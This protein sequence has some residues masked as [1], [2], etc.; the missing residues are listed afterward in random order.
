MSILEICLGGDLRSLS[1]L[2]RNLHQ[3]W[4]FVSLIFPGNL[5]E[6]AMDTVWFRS[7][8]AILKCETK[9]SLLSV[10]YCLPVKP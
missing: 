6:I 1:A 8:I 4:E 7:G 2:I 3:K 9:T 10:S 5:T